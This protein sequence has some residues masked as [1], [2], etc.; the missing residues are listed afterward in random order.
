MESL[1]LAR[2][3]GEG[4]LLRWREMALERRTTTEVRR[5]ENMT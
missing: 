5:K 4:N 2:R 3:M 1:V